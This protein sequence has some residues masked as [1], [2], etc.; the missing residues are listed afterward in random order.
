MGAKEAQTRAQE[1]DGAPLREKAYS[2][3]KAVGLLGKWKSL[4]RPKHLGLSHGALR[5]ER[6]P[7]VWP[8]QAGRAGE[9]CFSR[10]TVPTGF[11][12]EILPCC[13]FFSLFGP[14]A[15]CPTCLAIEGLLEPLVSTH[16]SRHGGL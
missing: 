6:G 16:T 2:E 13:I 5:D 7:E 4:L 14:R 3:G 15:M 11:Y 10:P 12:S 9:G 1:Q 8:Q